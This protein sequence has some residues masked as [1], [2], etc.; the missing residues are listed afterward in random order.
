MVAENTFADFLKVAVD[1]LPIDRGNYPYVTARVKAKKSLLLPAE[2][3]E[4][5][6]QMAVP[7]I[8]RFLGEGQYHDEMLALGARYGG[9][10]LVEMATRDNLAKVFAQILAFSEGPLREMIGR[11]LDRWDV[12]NVKTIL[13]GKFYGA[14]DEEILEDV[15]AAGTLPLA[16]LEKLVARETIEEVVVDLEDT[17][18]VSAIL[19]LT[20]VGEEVT[21][22]A[23]YEDLLD[24][25]YYVNLLEAIPPTSEPTSLFHNFV[26][27]E[28]DVVN[29]KT[30]LRVRG[31]ADIQRH[32]LF[33]PK[34]RHLSRT[35]LREMAGL[36]L[37][38]VLQRLRKTPYH[39]VLAP[40]LHEDDGDLT[41]GIRSLEKWLLAQASTGAN[42]HPLSIL[43]VLNYIIAKTKEVENL[44]IIARGKESGLDVEQMR[45]M[46]VI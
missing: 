40:H 20:A 45:E 31:L 23:P 19:G 4:R 9:V 42:I 13:R 17:P 8:A 3:Y 22:L 24:R 32:R 29:L 34:G 35:A 41:R 11:Y 43:P 16:F 14:S 7:A 37:P 1:R 44:R 36:D 2:T 30:L 33:I 5:L 27:L 21:T 39:D 10:D 15:I 46:L 26:R 38:A 28:V 25:I 18:Y 6:L 12:W